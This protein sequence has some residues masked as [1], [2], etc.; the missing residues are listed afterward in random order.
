MPFTKVMIHYIWATKNRFPSITTELKPLLINHIADNARKKGIHIDTLNCVKDHIHF[1]ISLGTEQTI[2]K[3]AQLIKGESSY[4]VN[5][6]GTTADKFE[7]QDEYIVLS[8]SES[9]LAKV[10]TYIV[11]QEEHHKHKTLALA[12][13]YDEFLRIHALSA[14]RSKKRGN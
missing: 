5:Q 10:R 2:A 13:E 9:A 1:L 7:W 14:P 4:W 8:V 11:N 12:E 6:S 3:V